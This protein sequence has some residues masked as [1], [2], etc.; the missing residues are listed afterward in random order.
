MNDVLFVETTGFQRWVRKN[1]IGREIQRLKNTLVVNPIIGDV[2]PGGSGLRKVRMA[3]KG[4]GKR[5]G[6]RVIYFLVL[7]S[8]VI[9]LDGYAKNEQEDLSADE[10]KTLVKSAGELDLVIRKQLQGEKDANEN[11]QETTE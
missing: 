7:E 9:L 10:L 1:R 11:S 3:G 2:I 5:G 6:Y 4:K 8:A